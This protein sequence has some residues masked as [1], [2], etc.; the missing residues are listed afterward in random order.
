[1]MKIIKTI[2]III[3]SAYP[4]SLFS[5]SVENFVLTSDNPKLEGQFYVGNYNSTSPA[6]AKYKFLKWL[7]YY[8]AG[9]DLYIESTGTTEIEIESNATDKIAIIDEESEDNKIVFTRIFPQGINMR[10]MKGAQYDLLGNVDLAVRFV[11]EFKDSRYRVLIDRLGYFDNEFD[12]N[13]YI[14]A[15]GTFKDYRP[16]F[17][18]EQIARSYTSYQNVKN[19]P[20][21]YRS[22]EELKKAEKRKLDDLIVLLNSFLS[23]TGE[24]ENDFYDQP[25][26]VDSSFSIDENNTSFPGQ[27]IRKNLETIDRKELLEKTINWFGT[28]SEE[29]GLQKLYT[30]NDKVFI[31]AKRYFNSSSGLLSTFGAMTGVAFGEVHYYYI[32]IKLNNDSV[33]F[34]INKILWARFTSG[35]GSG[36]DKALIKMD[37]HEFIVDKKIHIPSEFNT[38]DF[39]GL[40]EFNICPAILMYNEVTNLSDL[41]NKRGK[42]RKARTKTADD[43]LAFYNDIYQNFNRNVFPSETV[44]EDW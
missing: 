19:L 13:S 36:L 24:F 29:L 44:E 10:V 16:F 35:C 40:K 8:N 23:T 12:S 37:E 26:I 41:F 11:V 6:E 15:Q 31:V 42:P 22:S 38:A 4:V 21:E 43:Q 39:G 33:D 7:T 2:I 17:N 27:S 34:G 5:Q 28:N 30:Y 1:M 18:E 9:E 14:M 25:K 32:E 20:L 3:L